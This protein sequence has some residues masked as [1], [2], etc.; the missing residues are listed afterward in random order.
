MRKVSL[1]S[2]AFSPLLSPGLWVSLSPLLPSGSSP[3]SV[4][5]VVFLLC[6]LPAVLLFPLFPLLFFPSKAHLAR[7]LSGLNVSVVPGKPASAPV[8]SVR[9]PNLAGHACR[10]RLHPGLVCYRGDEGGDALLTRRVVIS[11]VELVA[12][13]GSSLSIWTRLASLV[14]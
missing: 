3:L 9:V 2:V 14:A 11:E 1:S 7:L 13:Q 5:G 4:L 12:L 6:P 10:V 8:R